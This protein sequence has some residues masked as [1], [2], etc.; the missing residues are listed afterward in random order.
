VF[1]SDF[2]Y[3]SSTNI[4]TYADYEQAYFADGSPSGGRNAIE[5]GESQIEPAWD[6]VGTAVNFNVDA[7]D[8]LSA[9]Q[10]AAA[11]AT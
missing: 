7:P 8:G 10:Q 11:T 9:G 5:H 1:W 6:A 4:S 2:T 3:N